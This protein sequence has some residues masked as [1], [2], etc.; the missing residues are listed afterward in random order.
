MKFALL[1]G[2]VKYEDCL[3][4]IRS[5]LTNLKTFLWIWIKQYARFA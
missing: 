3:F 1:N 2:L 4:G 5:I